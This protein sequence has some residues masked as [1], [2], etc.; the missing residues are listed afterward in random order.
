MTQAMYTPVDICVPV[1][2]PARLRMRLRQTLLSGSDYLRTH[3][4]HVSSS[5]RAFWLLHFWVDGVT[6]FVARLAKEDVLTPEQY[7]VLLDVIGDFF[8]R[9][10][11]ELF[12]KYFDNFSNTSSI[13]DYTIILILFDEF[14]YKKRNL[15]DPFLVS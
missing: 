6:F 14:I 9:A 11:G 7:T 8:D 3:F 4:R 1:E 5:S 15:F 13:A 10:E 2:S 12:N